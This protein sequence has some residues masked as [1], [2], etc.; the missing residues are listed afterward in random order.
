MFGS[1]LFDLLM[2][3]GKKY[4]VVLKIVFRLKKCLVLQGNTG[5]VLKCLREFLIGT[6]K[7]LTCASCLVE[8]NL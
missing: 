4:Y 2:T 3:C 7:L 1:S 6:S 5:K 8:N